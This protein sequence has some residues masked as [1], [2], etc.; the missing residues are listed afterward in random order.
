SGGLTSTSPISVPSYIP[1]PKRW[2]PAISSFFN[3]DFNHIRQVRKSFTNSL[4]ST[5]PI[6]QSIMLKRSSFTWPVVLLAVCS[7]F[8]CRSVQFYK[9][10]DGPL[11]YSGLDSF[12][13]KSYPDS[14]NVVTFNLKK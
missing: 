5:C 4:T 12:Q 10:P 8:S 6:L 7:V 3:A 1:A 9:E 2:F 11:Y 13:T 14:L